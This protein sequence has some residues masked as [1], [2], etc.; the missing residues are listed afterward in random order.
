MELMVERDLKEALIRS[1]R[2]ELGLACAAPKPRD[3]GEGRD[4]CTSF[5]TVAR[6]PEITSG[7]PS[8]GTGRGGGPVVALGDVHEDKNP[9]AC[10]GSGEGRED[11]EATAFGRDLGTRAKRRREVALARLRTLFCGADEGWL[12]PSSSRTPTP[13]SS[14]LRSP[15]S[16]STSR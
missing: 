10:D 15:S 9:S 1:L 2:S 5:W 12:S 7:P 13:P 6:C 11:V 3:D 4:C 14:P 16:D 8:A